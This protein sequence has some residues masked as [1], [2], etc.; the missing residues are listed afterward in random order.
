MVIF[1]RARVTL[2]W[3]WLLSGLLVHC[4][5]YDTTLVKL[6]PKGYWE[7]GSLLGNKE[8][9][10]GSSKVH[11]GLWWELTCSHLGKLLL[12]PARLEGMNPQKSAGLWHTINKLNGKLV[13]LWF[14]QVSM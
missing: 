7:V 1:P 3:G 11:A 8:Q 12:K 14:L 4:Q 5:A 10:H 6:L 2:E 13:M 9:T